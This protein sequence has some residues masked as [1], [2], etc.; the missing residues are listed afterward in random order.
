MIVIVRPSSKKQVYGVL[1][2]FNLTAIEPPIWAALLAAQ[3]RQRGVDVALIDNEVEN[4]TY[5]ELLW[6]ILELKPTAVVISVCGHN[7]SAST[8]SMVSVPHISFP[9]TH[10]GIKTIIHGLHPSALPE[11]TLLK[12]NADAVIVGEGFDVIVQAHELSGVVYSENFPELD[13]L[14]RPAWDLLPLVEYRAHNWHCFGRIYD[15]SPYGVLFTSLGCPRKCSFCVIHAMFRGS[16]QVRYKSPQVVA[17]ELFEWVK[18]DI[19]NIRIL[20]ENFTLNKKHVSDICAAVKHKAEQEK[21]DLDELNIWAYASVDTVD[22]AMLQNIRS[23]GIKWLC[24]GFETGNNKIAYETGKTKSAG[25]WTNKIVEVSN[26]THEAGICINANWMFGFPQ[27][28]WDTMLQ[29][30]HLA[31][32]ICSEWANFYCAMAYPGSQLHLQAVEQ[33]LDLPKTWQGYS[34]YAKETLP[35]PTE[36]LA[37]RDVLAFRDYAFTTY[38]TNPYYLRLVEYGFGRDTKEHI[39]FMTTQTLERNLLT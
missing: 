30:L 9:L 16:R 7:P 36:T 22:S 26:L 3:C 6:R 39:E 4:L 18:Q 19:Y 21:F 12:T 10:Y 5:S 27:D 24:Y 33:A 37:A 31:Q 34:Q 11:L 35:L 13:L 23:I 25:N 17:D 32:Y 1:D 8:Q 14:P 29:T 28:T 15:R 2:D 38:F 20:D